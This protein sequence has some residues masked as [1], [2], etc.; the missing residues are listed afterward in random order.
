MCVCTCMCSSSVDC[1]PLMT[2]FY[3]RQ[4][5][6]TRDRSRPWP[7]LLMDDILPPTQIQTATFLSGR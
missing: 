5:M 4:S 1:R 3:F 7:L 2:A 6:D